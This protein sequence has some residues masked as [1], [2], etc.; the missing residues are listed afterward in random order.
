MRPISLSTATIKFEDPAIEADPALYRERKVF[1][2]S[3]PLIVV[4]ICLAVIFLGAAA[5]TT[6]LLIFCKR[7]EPT[8]DPF[9]I[10][11]N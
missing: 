1:G 10:P 4:C 2:L 11:S 6:L 3:V 5:I 9:I 8:S 7:P